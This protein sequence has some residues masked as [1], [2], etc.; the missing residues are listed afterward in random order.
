[1][2]KSIISCTA[3]AVAVAGVPAAPE[4]SADS[5][6]SFFNGSDLSLEI[7]PRFSSSI[8]FHL[9]M[10]DFV[11]FNMISLST[12]IKL[13]QFAHDSAIQS[14]EFI[15]DRYPG[16]VIKIENLG[17]SQSL[18]PRIVTYSLY[19]GITNAAAQVSYRTASLTAFWNGHGVGY[20]DW[21]RD[22]NAGS[23]ANS[24]NSASVDL[25]V[26]T[27]GTASISTSN[28]S[29]LHNSNIPH[30][31]VA[32]HPSSTIRVSSKGVFI[33][34][35]T[36]FV[37]IMDFSGD[38][39]GC[40]PLMLYDP[41]TQVSITI[42]DKDRKPFPPHINRSRALRTLGHIADNYVQ[43]M[44]W[45][46]TDSDTFFENVRIMTTQIRVW[47]PSPPAVEAPKDIA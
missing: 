34:L 46:E 37:R 12:A 15:D 41:A 32:T 11:T 30:L 10:M 45:T 25:R 18:T 38:F 36:A 5:R 17:R 16:C 2:I 42:L 23:S 39:E 1:M 14:R 33:I 24:T 40:L 44:E 20:V 22:P 35:M 4:T 13:L 8:T 31:M 43:R 27:N 28:I 7:D 47:R 29:T 26:N 3:I 6:C 9:E 21:L 19:S